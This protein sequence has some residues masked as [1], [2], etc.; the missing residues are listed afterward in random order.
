MT[1]ET[2]K[3]GQET[4]VIR[5]YRNGLCAKLWH[6]ENKKVNSSIL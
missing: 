5:I 6:K 3:S 1:L 2:Q 4:R